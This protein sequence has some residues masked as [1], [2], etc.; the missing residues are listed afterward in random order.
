[1]GI[2]AAVSKVRS[3]AWQCCRV[4]FI[5]NA[6]AHAGKSGRRVVLAFIGTA[7]AQETPEAAKTQWR[8][9]AD[10]VPPQGAQTRRLDG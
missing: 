3:C 5:P 4:H 8:A 9:V 10:K 7:F 1:M 6:L 2:K